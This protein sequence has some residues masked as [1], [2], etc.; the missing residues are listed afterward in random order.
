MVPLL[1]HCCAGIAHDRLKWV[2]QLQVV[3]HR[4]AH[5]LRLMEVRTAASAAV[6]FAGSHACVVVSRLPVDAA[7]V[8]AKIRKLA[9][10]ESLLEL[11][12]V[13]E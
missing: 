12:Q 2:L 3:I 6:A 1:A 5:P 9:A 8:M 13:A 10:L 11:I 4:G 7:K